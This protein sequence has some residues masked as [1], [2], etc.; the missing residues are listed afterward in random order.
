MRDPLDM[1]A[2]L[3]DDKKGLAANL[4]EAH[5]LCE[6]DRGVAVASLIELWMGETGRRIWCSCVASRQG[7]ASRH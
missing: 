1:L 5:T 7:D 6:Q 2:D 3:R 4:R